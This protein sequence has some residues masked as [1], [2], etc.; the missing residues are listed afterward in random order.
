MHRQCGR[1]S[2]SH[3]VTRGEAK[4]NGSNKASQPKVGWLARKSRL[5]RYSTNAKRHTFII[6]PTVAIP[7]LPPS[8]LTVGVAP[9]WAP[10]PAARIA[11][12]SV[13]NHCRPRR[14]A[15]VATNHSPAGVNNSYLIKA[16]IGRGRHFGGIFD[17][18][19]RGLLG[20]GRHCFSGCRRFPPFVG[21]VQFID[22]AAS[23][24]AHLGSEHFIQ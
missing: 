7:A 21:P 2:G 4:G 9:L 13:L 6:V 12:I 20:R 14:A 18:L 3:T 10:I 5:R 8:P 17:G 23:I 24:A 19:A 16:R 1:D 22:C 15:S 11:A